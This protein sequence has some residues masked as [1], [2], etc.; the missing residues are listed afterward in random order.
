[1]SEIAHSDSTLA[2]RLRA[3]TP[4]RVGLGRTGVSL[5]TCD[6]LDFQRSHAQARDAVHAR[7]E[8]AA[9]SASLTTMMDA[10]AQP[11]VEILRLH[12]AAVDRATYLQRPDLGRRLD[13]SSRSLLA[14]CMNTPAK[15]ELV[16]IVADGLS[17]LAVERHVPSLFK[18][19]LPRLQGRQLAPVCIVEQGRVAI[20]DEIG[21]ALGA[22][23]SVVLIGER[24]GLSSPDSL[25]AYI[26]WAPRVG[27]TDAERN[28]ISN[29]RAEGMSYAQAATQLEFYLAEARRR[30]LTGVALKDEAPQLKEG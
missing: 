13:E 8:A 16:L 26:T 14:S 1:M 29:I 17:A 3:L 7:M 28:C 18:E 4:A 10:P 21:S 24:P 25:G 11:R 2:A 19:L 9:L 6:L 23:I 22:E 15:C 27:R 20:G 5:E 30:Q 12:S